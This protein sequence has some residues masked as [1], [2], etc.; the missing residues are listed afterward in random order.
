MKRIMTVLGWWMIATAS[1]HAAAPQQALHTVALSEVEQAVA[2]A[3]QTQGVASLV[4]A[5]VEGVMRD[6]AFGHRTPL[7]ID[8]RALTATPAT[9]R[10]SANINFVADGTIVSVAP[11]QGRYTEMVMLPTAKHAL[12]PDYPLSEDDLEL[13]PYPLTAMRSGMLK[14][15]TTVIGKV[16]HRHISPNRPLHEDE[17]SDAR[18]VRKQAP[19]TLEYST[20]SISITTAGQALQAG[21]VGDVIDVLNVNSKKVVRGTVVDKQT[22]R[23]LPAST[24]GATAARATAAPPV[25]DVYAN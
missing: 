24:S 5:R 4:T 9:K 22:V 3:L 17:F 18:V 19:V 10:W 8:I 15:I 7:S 21:A 16:P 25:E 11:M 1:A 23:I 20:P 12:K 14:D 6:T 13:R 2:T